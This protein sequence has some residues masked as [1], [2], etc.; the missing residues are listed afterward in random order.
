M[1]TLVSADQLFSDS[2]PRS[3]PTTGLNISLGYSPE[4]ISAL[5]ATDMAQDI[6]FAREKSVTLV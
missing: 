2:E 3:K 4:E 5:Y 1:D 6:E